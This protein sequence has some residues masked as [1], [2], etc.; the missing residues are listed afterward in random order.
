[1]KKLKSI[2]YSRH[3]NSQVGKRGLPPLV[4]NTQP[5]IVSGWWDFEEKS[6][7]ACA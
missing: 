1:M 2:A 3:R 7:E 6:I 4:R 5:E